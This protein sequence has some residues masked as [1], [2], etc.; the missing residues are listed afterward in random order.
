MSKKRAKSNSAANRNVSLMAPYYNRLVQG[1][2]PPVAAAGIVGNMMAESSMNHKADNGKGHKGLLQ[3]DSYIRN[4][5]LKNYGDYSLN[6][7][8]QFILDGWHGNLKDSHIQGRFND[9]RSSITNN[10]ALNAA[11]FEKYYERSGGQLANERMKFASQLLPLVKQT[12]LNSFAQMP[13]YNAQYFEDRANNFKNRMNFIH[14][15][16]IQEPQQYK[17]FYPGDEN[18]SFQEIAKNQE[19]YDKVF[20]TNKSNAQDTVEA[21]AD[22]IPRLSG[23]EIL[24]QLLGQ[25]INQEKTTSKNTTEKDVLTQYKNFLDQFIPKYE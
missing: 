8:L 7:Q 10:V 3:N 17:M 13:S 12:N 22:S 25:T 21:S 5:H 15:S 11:N 1:G 19:L 16:L 14:P 9:Y 23:Y 4:Y 18:R 2:I 24:E 6:S 20:N